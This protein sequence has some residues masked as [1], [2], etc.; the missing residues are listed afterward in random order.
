MRILVYEYLTATGLGREASDP[1]HSMYR[2]GLVMGN[3]LRED[4]AHVPGVEVVSAGSHDAAIVIAPETDGILLRLAAQIPNFVGSSPEAIALT[5]DKLA[6]GEHWR[7]HGIR[8][9]ATTDR[10]PTACE[11]FPL[12]W[13]PRDGCGSTA[14]YLLQDRN[15]AIR[16]QARIK[17]GEHAG[18]MILQEFIPGRAASMAFLCGPKGNLPLKPTLQHL[19][20]DGRF[21]YLGGE[22]PIPPDLAE[23]AVKVATHAV[24]CVPGLK[25]YIGVDLV[26]GDAAD[27]SQDYAIEIN[28]RLTTSYLG[29][30]ALAEVNLAETM[31]RIALGEALPEL[32]WKPGGV[33][34]TA[35]GAVSVL[36]D[37]R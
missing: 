2:E 29:L 25:G 10:P 11:N 14:T 26:L 3:A 19:S 36:P 6:L 22:L 18:P 33:L 16:V 37:P 31:L 5:S 32:R 27:G 8:T 12:V 24:A 23:R 15:D 34:F 9:P 17:N 1:M 30:R 7:A 21:H 4:F 13:K 28:P 20:T 35:A